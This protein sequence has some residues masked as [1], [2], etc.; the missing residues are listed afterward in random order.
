MKHSIPLIRAPEVSLRTAGQCIYCSASG[1][2]TREHIIPG[3]LHGN[4][5]IDD[6]SCE[7]CQRTINKFE[8][9]VLRLNFGLVRDALG[10]RSKSPRSRK[11]PRRQT[12]PVRLP[13]GSAGE[14]PISAQMPQVISVA[15]YGVRP[16][17]ITGETIDFT[18]GCPQVA[19]E[20]MQNGFQSPQDSFGAAVAVPSVPIL[21]FMR[22]I[23]KIAHGYT[24]ANL[25]QNN[26]TPYLLNIILDQ[27][28]LIGGQFIGIAPRRMRPP[29]NALHHIELKIFDSEVYRLPGLPS[30]MRR[31]AVVYLDLFFGFD[32]PTYEVVVGELR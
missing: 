10:V 7:D 21:T 13:N 29:I 27:E 32:L 16:P 3:G 26:F 19:W 11:S 5:V 20:K 23:A 14:I 9:E 17:A 24:I 22:F 28:T 31:I 2:L 18:H 15:H 4:L 30:A 1:Q 6:A 8:T 12:Y 25:S